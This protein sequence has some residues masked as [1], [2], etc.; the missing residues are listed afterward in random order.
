MGRKNIGKKLRFEVFK[1]DS[2][3]CQYCGES[4]PDV[5]L[6]ID[7]IKPVADGG[8]N[9][10]ANL[11]TSCVDCNSGKGA[12]LLSDKTMVEKQRKQ[13][14]ELNERREQL[15][16]MLE[17]RDGLMALEEEQV[18]SVCERFERWTKYTVSEN[19]EKTLR[20]LIK[21][22]GVSEVIESMML[23][24]AQYEEVEKIFEYIGRICATRRKNSH[25][26]YMKDLYYIRGILKNRLAYCNA[27]KA[28]ELLEGAHLAGV[29]V[30]DLTTFAKTVRNWT[31]FSSAL[32]SI[33]E[34]DSDG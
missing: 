19:G 12:R 7:H 25:R 6:H 22:Y 18:K 1:R 14:E 31:A 16:L 23:S 24:V 5:V 2:F 21:K 32:E 30:E 3:K 8:D 10:L 34:G 17:W 29:A 27:Q 11:I 15:E 13:L 20:T 33:I 9:D 26:P 28:I 4:A